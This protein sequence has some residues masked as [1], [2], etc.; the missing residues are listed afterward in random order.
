MPKS[1][2]CASRNENAKLFGTHNN[3]NA[4]ENAGVQFIPKHAN[5]IGQNRRPNSLAFSCP[6]EHQ[7]KQKQHMKSAK[8]T[9]QNIKPEQQKHRI[10]SKRI[11]THKSIAYSRELAK[12]KQNVNNNKHNN[13]TSK[14]KHNIRT[15]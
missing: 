12:A 10:T 15:L 13:E 4:H 5:Q 3:P 2:A 8:K 1:L 14:V 7:E 9:K 11:T 6:A